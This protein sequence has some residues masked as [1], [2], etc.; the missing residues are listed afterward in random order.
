[1]SAVCTWPENR[2][3]HVGVADVLRSVSV[4]Q[5]SVIATLINWLFLVAC[6]QTNI[7]T[8]ISGTSFSQKGHSRSLPCSFCLGFG[9]IVNRSRAP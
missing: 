8:N 2:P 3:I 7:Q 9:P 4:M 6:V 5:E 1:M